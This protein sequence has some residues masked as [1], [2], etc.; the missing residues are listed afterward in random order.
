MWQ[1]GEYY[2][3]VFVPLKF[4]NY[5]RKFGYHATAKYAARK[6]KMFG[7]ELP[8]V[9]TDEQTHNGLRSQVL[10]GSRSE[11][12]VTRSKCAVLIRMPGPAYMNAQPMVYKVLRSVLPAELE[13]VAA[14]VGTALA[15]NLEGTAS[16]ADGPGK[17]QSLSASQE[18]TFS[19]SK[20]VP[21]PR[22]SMKG[23]A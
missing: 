11:A 17:R 4:T 7:A 21:K 22:R 15:A 20:T 23:A 19:R 13:R 18:A 6:R 5:A 12:R 8:L 10:A 14:I 2:R 9:F 1:G 16:P 3:T